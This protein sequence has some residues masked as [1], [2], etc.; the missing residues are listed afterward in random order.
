MW[1]RGRYAPLKMARNGGSRAETPDRRVLKDGDVLDPD[2]L[3]W[4]FIAECRANW[5]FFST[6]L[7][8]GDAQ[9]MPVGSS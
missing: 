4:G 5:T 1:E 2:P 9:R 3:T 6:L 7:D 8:H